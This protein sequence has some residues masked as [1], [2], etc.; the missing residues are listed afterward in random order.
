[1]LT[2]A[3]ANGGPGLS[4]RFL[5]EEESSSGDASV[6]TRPLRVVGEAAWESLNSRKTAT[7][8]CAQVV[9]SGQS[10]LELEFVG[11][12]NF[13]KCLSVSFTDI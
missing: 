8:T 9:P 11:S 2:V 13:V 3:G 10:N 5:V 6:I 4:A 12:S 1:M 7:Y